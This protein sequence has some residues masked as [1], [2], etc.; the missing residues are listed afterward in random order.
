MQV[1][2]TA[3][4]TVLILSYNRSSGEGWPHAH[5]IVQTL[6]AVASGIKG[7]DRTCYQVAS[8][9]SEARGAASGN[10]QGKAYSGAILPE[11]EIRVPAEN[12]CLHCLFI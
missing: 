5:L 4:V 6:V 12:R 7:S 2:R 3:G 11:R 1:A 10:V 8:R 9:R